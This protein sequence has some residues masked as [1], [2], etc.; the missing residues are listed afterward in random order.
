MKAQALRDNSMSTYMTSKKTL[1]LNPN[2]S[3]IKELKKK[4]EADKNDRT[5]KDLVLLMFETSLLSSGF[6]LD[7]PNSFAARINRMI[8]LGLSIDDTAEEEAQTQEKV[9]EDLP[10]LEND[11]ANSKMEEID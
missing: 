8:K 9:D 6:T 2:N 5:A 11:E 4:I 10:P 3:V 1:E 7:E